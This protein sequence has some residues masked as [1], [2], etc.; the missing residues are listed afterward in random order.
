M[1]HTKFSKFGKAV[2]VTVAMVYLSLIP[3]VVAWDY[4]DHPMVVDS[5]NTND[6]I[7]ID[8]HH[9]NYSSGNWPIT[10]EGILDFSV[11]A[12]T[13]K[14]YDESFVC[15]VLDKHGN[16]IGRQTIPPHGWR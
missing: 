10:V 1:K 7:N 13:E 5:R 12:V 16:E 2:I 11:I 9:A 14:G 3:G 15:Q 4:P 8:T 6:G